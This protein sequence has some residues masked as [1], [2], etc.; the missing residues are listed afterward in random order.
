MAPLVHSTCCGP[1]W[2]QRVEQ[3]FLA[4]FESVVVSR[5]LDGFINLRADAHRLLAIRP[6]VLVEGLVLDVLVC[7][8]SCS[9]VPLMLALVSCSVAVVGATPDCENPMVEIRAAPELLVI[10]RIQL[11][12]D[13]VCFDNG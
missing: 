10:A 6:T 11:G 7:I 12:K 1:L 3:R 8:A 9:V 13:A 5:Q 2:P 4:R